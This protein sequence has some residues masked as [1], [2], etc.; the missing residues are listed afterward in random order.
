MLGPF[1][2][3]MGGPV[4]G[5]RQ[6]VSWIAMDDLLGIALRAIED[7]SLRGAVNAVAPGPVT[8][9]EF[10]SMLARLMRRPAIVP[11]PA[12]AVRLLFGE[13]GEALLLA[14]TRVRP[15]RLEAAGFAFRHPD[16]ESALRR[17]LGL[18]A[19]DGGGA[20]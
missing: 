17:E 7:E 12:V 18:S 6:Y 11:L 8:N 13:M 4:G 2:M 3:G 16:L 1:R 10:V 15:A 20:A 14:S 5:G 19:S 9:A